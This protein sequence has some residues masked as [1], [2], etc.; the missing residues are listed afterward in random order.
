MVDAAVL[1][2]PV[3]ESLR[4]HHAH[5][6]CHV[7]RAIGYRST[8]ATFSAVPSEPAA[9]DWA[10]LAALV[11]PEGVADLFSC[12]APPPP[13]WEPVFDVA[14]VQMVGA[15]DR[16]G[17]AESDPDVVALGEADVP[18]MMDLVARTRPGPF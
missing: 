2:D 5:L 12:P 11:G 6:A 1:D 18:E 10:D 15:S 8:V 3:G 4:G 13:G 7:G 16:L 9:E 17:A 14:G